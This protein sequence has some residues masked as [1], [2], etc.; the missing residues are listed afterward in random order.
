VI[1]DP[2]RRFCQSAIGSQRTEIETATKR[3]ASVATRR[4]RKLSNAVSRRSELDTELADQGL[5]VP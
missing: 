4:L 2:R 3:E 1:A 5:P